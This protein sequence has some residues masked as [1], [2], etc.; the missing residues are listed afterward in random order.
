MHKI[1]ILI[2]TL[3]TISIGCNDDENSDF[4]KLTKETL[5]GFVQKGPFIN[6]TSITVSELDESLVQTGNAFN[7]QIVDNSGSFELRDLAL[8]SPFVQIKAEGFYFDEVMGEKS[9]AQLTLFALSD[10]SSKDQINVNVLTHL[11]KGRV[12]F[13][14]GQSVEFNQAKDSAQHE[15]L[16]AFG[17][18]NQNIENSEELDI[19]V[20]N[21]G[22]ATLI[23]I[24]IILQANNSV[25]DLTELLADINTDFRQ[26]GMINSESIKSELFN[27]TQNLDLEEIRT[28]LEIRYSELGLSTTIPDFE[29]LIAQYLAFQKPFDIDTKISNV[30]CKGVSNGSIDITVNEGIE[31]FTYEWSNGMTTE[32]IE[33]LAPGNY[34]VT[35]IDANDYVMHK[36]D[37]IVSELDA[38]EASFSVRHVTSINGSDG[39]ITLSVSGGTEPYI[40]EWSNSETTDNLQNL[41]KG[42]Y[43]VTIQDSNSCSTQL[44]I[45][46][47]EPV[48]L[49]IEKTDVDCFGEDQ[50]TIN[51]SIDGGLEPYS[52]QWSN[53]SQSVEL[54]S[55]TA[56]TYSVIVTDELG[57]TTEESVEITQ[58]DQLQLDSELTHPSSNEN[59][60]IIVTPSGGTPPYSFKWSNGS[61]TETSGML[62]V[63]EHY[64]LE[65]MVTDAN[66]CSIIRS[67]DIQNNFVDSRDGRVYKTV[68]IGDQIWMA[69]NLKVGTFIQS[70]NNSTDNSTIE[71]YLLNDDPDYTGEGV[72]YKWD[73]AM[74]YSSS[75]AEQG[76]CPPGWHIPTEEEWLQLRQNLGGVYCEIGPQLQFTGTSGFEMEPTGSIYQLHDNPW[77]RTGNYAFWLSS[78]DQNAE[79]TPFSVGW[80]ENYCAEH[81][82]STSYNSTARPIRCIKD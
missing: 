81:H 2:I 19:S 61:T 78:T 34:S 47:Q 72:Y 1:K 58:T 16:S 17:L 36:N 31:P 79:N 82:G 21:S 25:A 23:A 67:F 40:F 38:L 76:I 5:S 27:T 6:G 30:T 37:I 20:N 55:L 54:A 35:I 48:E 53:G 65:V 4:E 8:S 69:E 41:E 18:D 24:S 42:F 52:I 70:T 44:E 57:Y 33:N 64:Q 46:V 15:L 71:K 22:N 68:K 29:S 7:T 43:S 60:S 50:G 51:L 75:E 59:G 63:F 14:I 11:E 12:E 74:N 28:N 32:D 13:L 80:G 62:E 26:D 56:S 9:S 73:E 39:S 45:A 77:F 10:I 66:S 49:L 3:L